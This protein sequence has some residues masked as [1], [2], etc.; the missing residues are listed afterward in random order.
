MAWNNNQDDDLVQCSPSCDFSR[1]YGP[2]HVQCG[3]NLRIS[4]EHWG[5]VCPHWVREIKKGMERQNEK[6]RS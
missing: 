1:G 2:T 3:Y 4:H 5:T 6:Q